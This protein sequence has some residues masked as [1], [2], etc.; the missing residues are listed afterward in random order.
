MSSPLTIRPVAPADFPLEVGD[1]LRGSGIQVKVDRTVFEQRRRRKLDRQ[2][3]GM[4]RAQRAAEADLVAL[5]AL[6][7]ANAPRR[8]SGRRAK[9]P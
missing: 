1:Y 9:T 2:I 7:K 5:A 4:R 3:D 6:V 8:R